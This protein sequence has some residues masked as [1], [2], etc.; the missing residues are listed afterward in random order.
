MM[1]DRVGILGGHTGISNDMGDRNKFAVMTGHTAVRREFSRS[2]GCD[3]SCSAFHSGVAISGVR[4][5]ELIGISFPIQIIVSDEVEQSKFVV[6]VMVSN[7]RFL[8]QIIVT[9]WDTKY[10][11]NTQLMNSLE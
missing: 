1:H 5:D 4:C 3:E 7:S 8:R 10:R 6:L 2:E 9:S 11:S